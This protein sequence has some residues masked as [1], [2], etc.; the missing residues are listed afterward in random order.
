MSTNM[1]SIIDIITETGECGGA[2]PCNT[3]GMGNPLPTNPAEQPGVAGAP[4]SEPVAKA[5]KKCKKKKKVDESLLDDDD[6]IMADAEEATIRNWME[7]H[8]TCKSYKLDPKTKKISAGYLNLAGPIPSYIKFGSVGTFYL[9][10]Y[11]VPN[12]CEVELPDEALTVKIIA[13][14]TKL[15]LKNLV[16][17]ELIIDST[18]EEIVLPKKF[19]VDTLAIRDCNNLTKIENLKGSKISY[20]KLP[21]KFCGELVKQQLKLGSQSELFVFGNKLT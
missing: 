4:G 14:P 7:N 19:K 15:I 17:K 5:C 20:I 8:T 13:N 18:C 2:T 3:M 10:V 11:D 12:V 9:T 21:P 1:K 6:K 16:A